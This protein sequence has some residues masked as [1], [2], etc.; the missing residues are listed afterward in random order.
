MMID[1]DA[2]GDLATPNGSVSAKS[3]D[4]SFSSNGR[5]AFMDL[6]SDYARI[7]SLNGGG[8]AVGLKMI[9]NGSPIAVAEPGGGFGNQKWGAGQHIDVSAGNPTTGPGGNAFDG[10]I[11]THQVSGNYQVSAY[12]VA[13]TSGALP[14]WGPISEFVSRATFDQGTN[15]ARISLTAMAPWAGPA[16]NDAADDFR[17]QMEAGGTAT[18]KPLRITT[19]YNTSGLVYF[20]QTFEPSGNVRFFER[21]DSPGVTA[22]NLSLILGQLKRTTAN[23]LTAAGQQDSPKLVWEGN[24]Y[25]TSLH[26]ARMRAFVDVTSNAGA[27]DLR[28]QYQIDAGGWVNRLSLSAAGIQIHGFGGSTLSGVLGFNYGTFNYG[29]G[30]DNH[31]LVSTDQTQTLSNKILD[32]STK[33][34]GNV[35]GGGNAALGSNC[36][37]TAPS[38][39]FTWLAVKAADGSTV[40]IP[41]W[42]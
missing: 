34:S 42:K 25:D 32:A 30:V 41:A 14:E 31:T 28:F 23:V 18:M 33:F 35:I 20:Q 1:V 16:L 11:L 7:G 38:A 24:A 37:A 13:A 40:H 19:Q 17:I 15:F 10:G 29:D 27:A 21:T 6:A 4:N 36:P 26:T 9:N 12:H 5:R 2:N 22:D 39:P 8:A 3:G